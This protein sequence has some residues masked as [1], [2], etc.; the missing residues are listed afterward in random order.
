VCG[1]PAEAEVFLEGARVWVCSKCA[2]FGRVVKPAKPAAASPGAGAGPA[3]RARKL[4]V[5]EGFG[6]LVRRAREARGFS[7]GDFAKKIFVN[8]R[9][10]ARIE[11]GELRPSV[12]VARK[13]ERELG[14][15]LLVEE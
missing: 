15:T 4:V 1:A 14:I 2:R 11:R 10:L 3:V 12:A 7:V 6:E 13:L 5:A 8:E 9:E